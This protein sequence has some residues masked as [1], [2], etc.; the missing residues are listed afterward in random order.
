MMKPEEIK[1][2]FG[3]DFNIDSITKGI[4]FMMEKANPLLDNLMK[5]HQKILKPKEKKNIK[6]NGSSCNAGLIEDGRVI[7]NF[8]SL[9]EAKKYYDDIQYLSVSKPW[10]KKIFGK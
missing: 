7:V 6:L 10:Y 4:E 9:D 2:I 3:K 8:S 5:E 1:K